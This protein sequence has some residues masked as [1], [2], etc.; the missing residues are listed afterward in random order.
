M[1]PRL[2]IFSEVSFQLAHIVS[3]MKENTLHPGTHITVDPLFRDKGSIDALDCGIAL[4]MDGGVTPLAFSRQAHHTCVSRLMLLL[5]LASPCGSVGR[6]A[7]I[8][9]RANATEHC[10]FT[11][12]VSPARCAASASDFQ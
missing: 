12:E 2:L 6:Y 11:A 8:C 3:K 4:S 5:L 9:P 7:K 10:C 1:R